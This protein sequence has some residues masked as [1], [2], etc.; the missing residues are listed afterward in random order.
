MTSTNGNGGGGGNSTP[1]SKVWLNRARPKQGTYKVLMIYW[2]SY[3]TA[4]VF[5]SE[6]E[7]EDELCQKFLL[8]HC[9]KARKM[10]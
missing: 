1:P 6:P 8:L 5:F 3:M 7:A 2:T 10:T 4:L 9:G